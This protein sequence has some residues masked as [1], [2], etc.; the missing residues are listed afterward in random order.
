MPAYTLSKQSRFGNYQFKQT[1]PIFH[2][3]SKFSNHINWHRIHT[4]FMK[5]I[6]R[7]H[8]PDWLRRND[9]KFLFRISHYL[10][11]FSRRKSLKLVQSFQFLLKLTSGSS[12][13]CW[14]CKDVW[15]FYFEDICYQNNWRFCQKCWQ[16]S[17]CGKLREE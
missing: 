9:M 7:R 8:S 5:R 3:P 16:F 2:C 15:L 12:E 10:P 6:C 17:S 13:E 4:E 1:W 11:W 14:I